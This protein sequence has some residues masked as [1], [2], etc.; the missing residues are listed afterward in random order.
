VLDEHG[1]FATRCNR[2]LVDFEEIEEAD[3]IELRSLVAEHEART[4]STVAARVL[5]DWEALLGS[6]VKV[7]PRDY[8]RA[9]AELAE[10]EKES[11]AELAQPMKATDERDRVADVIGAPHAGGGETS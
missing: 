1:A 2:E 5:R 4:G 11:D 10:A 7:M 6:F 3:A 8:K 9:L